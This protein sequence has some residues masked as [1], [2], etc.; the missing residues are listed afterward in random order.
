VI[1]GATGV[2]VGNE[3]LVESVEREGN[4]FRKEMEGEPNVKGRMELGGYRGVRRWR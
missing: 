2:L 4:S 1:N 3:V